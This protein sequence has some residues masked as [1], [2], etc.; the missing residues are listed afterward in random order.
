MTFAVTPQP[1]VLTSK[2]QV[3]TESHTADYCPIQPILEPLPNKKHVNIDT[4]VTFKCKFKNK[5]VP[6]PTV[7]WYFSKDKTNCRNK[8]RVERNDSHLKLSRDNLTLSVLTVKQR[9][10]GCYVVKAFNSV[11]KQEQRSYLDID[12]K[13]LYQQRRT[14]GSKHKQ[15]LTVVAITAVVVLLVLFVSVLLYVRMHRHHRVSFRLT[16]LTEQKLNTVYISHHH[17]TD[18]EIETL[19][20]F[21]D[22]LRLFS[23]KVLIDLC[24]PLYSKKEDTTLSWVSLNIRRADKIVVLLTQNYIETLKRCHLNLQSGHCC[25]VCFEFAFIQETLKESF[26]KSKNIVIVSNIDIKTHDFPVGFQH[27]IIFW[28]P[29]KTQIDCDEDLDD[30]F[31]TF[32]EYLL[33]KEDV[34]LPRQHSEHF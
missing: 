8:T 24:E 18:A 12:E 9:H 4:D 2:G 27:R 30:D 14:A 7:I 11:G 33:E 21:V 13:S 19:L 32:L 25:K 3:S 23:I 5:P 34:I 17:E 29:M 22:V 28:F 26:E 1:V 31:R 10:T 15:L 20:H 6:Q 16:D